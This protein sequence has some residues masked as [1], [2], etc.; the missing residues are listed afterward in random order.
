M[1]VQANKVLNAQRARHPNPKLDIHFLSISPS[2]ALSLLVETTTP[3]GSRNGPRSNTDTG[4]IIDADLLGTSS[5]T[6]DF[7]LGI[8]GKGKGS[9]RSAS[10]SSW[11]T[12]SPEDL[13]WQPQIYPPIGGEIPGCRMHFGA[14]VMGQYLFVAG[15]TLPTTLAYA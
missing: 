4:L 10:S 11:K 15:G 6:F 2:A 9:D 1:Y 5:N 7:G 8:G 3:K 12:I 13:R 14:A